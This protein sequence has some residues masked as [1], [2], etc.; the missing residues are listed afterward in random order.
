MGICARCHS[1]AQLLE[2]EKIIYLD[3][4]SGTYLYAFQTLEPLRSVCVYVC[5]MGLLYFHLMEGRRGR[6]PLALK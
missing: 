1:A 2:R 6:R 5:S 3:L 4:L